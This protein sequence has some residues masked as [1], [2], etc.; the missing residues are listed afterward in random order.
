MRRIGAFNFLNGGFSPVDGL[1]RG[2]APAE[3]A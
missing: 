2:F 3:V 1:E